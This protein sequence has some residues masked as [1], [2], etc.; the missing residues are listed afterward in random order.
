MSL[1]AEVFLIF[2]KGIEIKH[3]FE[4]IEQI[5]SHHCIYKT[6]FKS[7]KNNVTKQMLNIAET[8]LIA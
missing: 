2:F 7:W 5:F 1:K 4:M 6:S 3:W 8:I